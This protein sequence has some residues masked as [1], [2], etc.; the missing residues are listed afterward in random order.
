MIE[1]LAR[2]FAISYMHVSSREEVDAA[3]LY[4]RRVAYRISNFT[5]HGIDFFSFDKGDGVFSV[6]FTELNYSREFERNCSEIIEAVFLELF[7][8]LRCCIGFV[9]HD[10]IPSGGFIFRR[11]SVI[12]SSERLA[13]VI[14][15]IMVSGELE[16]DFEWG[17][18]W[19]EKV[20]A[21]YFNER[22]WGRLADSCCLK[23]SSRKNSNHK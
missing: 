5:G 17:M 9:L 6:L 13:G 8:D 23:N 16:G 18:Y 20:N 4:L 14:A 2:P 7:D 22:D 12:Y 11:A 1:M 3:E 15:K 10:F 19:K 21:K